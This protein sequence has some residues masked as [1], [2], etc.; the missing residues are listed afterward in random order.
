MSSGFSTMM[1]LLSI[2]LFFEHA[3]MVPF[4]KTIVFV[5]VI[6]DGRIAYCGNLSVTP[7]RHT[8]LMNDGRRLGYGRQTKAMAAAGSSNGRFFRTRRNKE[9]TKS[10]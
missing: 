7:F 6:A 2:F 10:V 1:I 4:E 5:V 3:A 8:R 9:V